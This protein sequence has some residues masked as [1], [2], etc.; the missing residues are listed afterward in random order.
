MHS[1]LMHMAKVVMT[2]VAALPTVAMKVPILN[3]MV[4]LMKVT[5]RMIMKSDGCDD[6][7]GND[8]NDNNDDVLL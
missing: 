6:K 4:A 5:M 1:L 2:L 3:P 8:N 7:D